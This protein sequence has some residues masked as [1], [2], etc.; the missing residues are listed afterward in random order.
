MHWTVEYSL[1]EADT[2]LTQRTLFFNP[3]STAH[4]WMSWSNAGVP[5][6]P[7]TEFHFPDGPVLSHGREVKTIDW[8]HRG[9]ATPGGRASAWSDSSGGNR[10]VAPL[11]RSLRVWVRVFT[12]LPIPN[13]TPGIKLWTDGVGPHQEWVSQYTLNR[14]QCLEIQAG[15]LVDQ[16]IKD[17]L[18]P[19][20]Q[21]YHVEF[22]IP[23]DTALNI[24][25]NSSSFSA[26]ATY[27]KDSSVWL[28]PRTG[29][30][31]LEGVV[32]RV[33]KSAAQSSAEPSRS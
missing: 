13:L 9:P 3:D 5:A 6:R 20:Q 28:G 17:H 7:D 15:P 2:F 21:R 22:W 18:Q 24:E 26:I 32:A 11:A 1:G 29:S 8:A 16:S 27:R 30:L 23:S 12:T 31:A 10:V 25:T 4:P 19:G 14:D 33:P